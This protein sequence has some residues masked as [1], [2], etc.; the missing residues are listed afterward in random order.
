MKLLALLLLIA[1]TAISAAEPKRIY[2]AE[3]DHTDYMWTADADTFNRTFVEMLDWHLKLADETASNP[4][5]YR[6]RFNCDG[7]YWLWNYEQRKSPAEFEKLISRIK[8]GT[9]SAPLNTL[10][11]CYGGMPAEAVLRSMYYSGR[12]ERR[13]DIRFPLAT[14]MENQ[15][16]PLGL[17]SLF[18]GAGA[19]FSWRGVCGCA[20]RLPFKVLSERP[21][22]VS[23]WTGLDNRK[24]LLKWYSLGP[25]GV[26]GYWEAGSPEAAINY[27]TSDPNFLR[28]QVDSK[29]K[30]PYDVIGLFGFGGDDLA[31]KTGITPPPEIP[32]V[33]GLQKVI[34][35]PRVEHFHQIAKEQSNSQRQVIVSNELDFF[36]DFE[37]TH[38]ANLESQSVTFGNEWDLYSASMSETSARA[39]RA[40]EKLRA[41]ELLAAMVSLK[42]PAFMNNH[43]AARDR[44]FN[45]MGLYW[46]HNWTADGPVSRPH[47]AAWEEEVVAGIE[48]YVNSI[49]GEAIVRLGGMIPRPE[50]ANRFFVVNPLG[51]PRTEAADFGYT[52][53][54]DIHVRDLTTSKDVPHQIVKLS[55]VRILRILASDIP[56]AGYKVFEIQPGKGT[57]ATD[58]AATTND[59]GSILENS[60]VKLVIE[61]D[62]AI[63]NFIDKRH[64]NTELA[65]EIFDL[66]LNDFAAKTDD[67]EALRVVNR[68]PVSMT[69][70]ARSEAGVPHDTY[71]TLYRD[72]DR[73]DIR[74]EI[75]E[76]FC[77]VRYW[78]FSFGIKNPSVH[79][80]E[81]GAVILDK[82]KADGGHYADSHARYDHITVNHFADISGSDGKSG[83]TLSNPDLAFAKLGGSEVGTLDWGTPQINMLAGGQIDGPNLGIRGQNGN[84]HFL[85]RFALLGHGGYNQ[86]AAMK[87]ALEHQNPF[88]TGPVISK[89]DGVYPE[90]EFSLLGI[91]NPEVLLWALKSHEDGITNGLVARVWN[92]SEAAQPTRFS[93][94]GRMSAASRL[95]HI[96]TRIEDLPVSNGT[97]ETSVG[98]Q[99][100]ETYQLKITPP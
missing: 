59:E 72:S 56:S 48:G 98:A 58:E 5:E 99:R 3:D 76:N 38:G 34:S 95:S 61:R 53:S 83:V 90:S 70:R 29:T 11:S 74:N 18:S 9:I 8:D 79:T 69:V 32:A 66:K 26:G 20:S 88:V 84:T 33:P 19:K 78:A 4:P 52:G 93:L 60:A 67:G 89:D 41:A 73:V 49:Q 80:E 14:A 10:V 57:A 27:A 39:K 47:R 62:G 54:A 50:N 23:W 97:L 31:R 40:V 42:Y 15:T 64:G 46:E 22:E 43:T 91:D 24:L 92:Q 13:Y 82:P 77:D 2:I 7:S 1:A 16:L 45:G 75:T 51:W 85:Q 17:T 96:E 36:E 12:L 44:A 6:H 71:I 100:M 35:S 68:G 94:A 86:T 87:F 25:F 55:G 81:V 63:R 65:A 21:R 37:K 30:Q 28:R